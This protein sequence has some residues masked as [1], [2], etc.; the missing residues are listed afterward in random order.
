MLSSSTS[1][2][3]HQVLKRFGSLVAV[4]GVSLRVVPG[5]LLAL[6]G[7]SGCGKS[8]TLRLIAGL[9]QPDS[10]TII[11]GGRTV[12]GPDQW[13]PPEQRR[14]G[15]VFQDGALFPHLTVAENIAFPLTASHQ[16]AK[17]R[18]YELMALVGLDGLERR[19][20]HQLSGGQQQRV[21]LA[22]ALAVD[23]AVILLDE[24]FANLDA[25]L[26]HSLRE[27]V[28]QL[29]R[30]SGVTAV[31]V[32][33]DQAEALS[34]ADRVAVLF[35]GQIAQIDTPQAI[36]TTPANRMVAAFVGEVNLLPAEAQGTLANS[37]IGTII[38]TMPHSGPVELA[39]RPEAIGVEPHPDGHGQIERI[40][41]YGHDQMLTILL[42]N[43]FKLRAR[44]GPRNDLA[45]G[46]R[47]QLVVRSAV[48]AFPSPS[49]ATVHDNQL[50]TV[51][52]PTRSNIQHDIHHRHLTN[53]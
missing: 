50:D 34:L 7:P 40:A 38:L 53:I 21:A 48:S 22:R 5:E 44:T 16:Q 27:E 4:D 28:A 35:A 29:V 39:L 32:T 36:Y 45:A 6:L 25:A 46:V 14:V 33:H 15:L 43:G 18:T 42:P 41:F 17:A 10:G 23:P 2:E 12:A 52:N 19:Y 3:L 24:P 9:E 20:P 1:I 8:T 51:G 47:V 49:L 11:V 13:T 31:L 37:P 26:R 30:R